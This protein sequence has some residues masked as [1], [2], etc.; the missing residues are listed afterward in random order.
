VTTGA[1]TGVGLGLRW[2]FLEE[3]TDRVVAGERLPIDF[4]EISPEN[5]VRRGGW[6]VEALELLRDHFPI[7]THGLSLSLGGLDP[8]DAGYLARVR[9][10]T[11]RLGAPW[12]SDHLCFSGAGGRMTHE[13]LPLPRTRGAA[14]HL[15]ERVRAARDALEL[16]IA[17]E[18]ITWYLEL[19]ASEIEEP[20]FVAEVLEGADC[21]LLLDVNNVFVNS[22][23]HG[24]DPARWLER[25]DLGRVVEIHVAGFER[26]DA[27]AL[28][29]DTHGAE[30]RPEV[31]ALLERALE[32]TGPVAVVLERDNHV[33]ALDVLLA[34][35]AG[36][37][38]T[39]ERALRSRAPAPPAPAVVA[40]RAA[41][42]PAP[43]ALAAAE[44]LLRRVIQIPGDARM[45]VEG[46]QR[47]G[48]AGASIPE[49]DARALARTDPR[50]LLVY[51][52]I[53]RDTLADTMRKQIPRTVARLG[54]G[55]RPWVDRFCDDE[56]PRSLLI[57]DAPYELVA[58]ALE[59]WQEDASVPPYLGD[60]ARF[61]LL[62]F[63]VL[64]AERA[65][66]GHA[67]VEEGLDVARAVRFD[68]TTRLGRFAHAVH[69]LVDAEG[70][71]TEPSLAP[72]RLLLYRDRDNEL[73]NLALSPL[74]ASLLARLLFDARALGDA[75]RE[76]CAE[77]GVV[78][79]APVVD[80][81]THLF[82]DLAERGVLL[83]S[84]PA[85]PRPAP[86]PWWRWL[87]DG[88]AAQLALPLL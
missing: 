59:R 81:T 49:A 65:P 66:W 70:D 26:R 48:F 64:T 28:F 27:D 6:V 60:L 69:E 51:R 43:P 38:A 9:A 33:P 57:R 3:L 29:V 54:P 21:A 20:D 56:L 34:E 74:A 40:G 12:H 78:L 23:N 61:E 32:R 14:R 31:H 88:D 77:H 55:W 13:L 53:V 36:I 11:R 2:E 63:E 86:T 35:L 1:L 82:A 47:D 7:V 72:T 24:F 73:R 45:V 50:R 46:L 75:L 8:L 87:A 37:R 68:G 42:E 18:N 4:F 10:L 15:A 22:L 80:G 52:A 84:E 39:Y 67:A 41:A 5:Y 58:W 79:D 76:A 17:V 71:R 85:A 30:I 83:G 25:I 44:L 16:P 62:E 19:G